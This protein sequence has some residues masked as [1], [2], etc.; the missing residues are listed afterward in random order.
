MPSFE[1][2]LVMQRGRIAAAGATAEVV[3]AAM[4]ESLYGIGV[5]RLDESAG[6]LWPI[7]RAE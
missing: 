7:W 6:R 5:E 2:T 3:T 1:S 4:L